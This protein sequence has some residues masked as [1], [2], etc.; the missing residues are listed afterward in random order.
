MQI[1]RYIRLLTVPLAFL[2]AIG[3]TYFINFVF[4]GN[5]IDTTLSNILLTAFVM[6]VGTVLLMWIGELITEKGISNGISL[7]I[8]AS[9]VAGIVG[10]L[11]SYIL[12]A[13]SQ[14]IPV[15]LFIIF[16]V[17]SLIILSIL[18]IKTVKEI[19]IVY[20]RHGKIEETAVLPIPLNPVGMI[21]IIFAM[22]FVS[23]PY[24]IAQ[25]VL[26]ANIESLKPIAEWISQNLNLYSQSPSPLAIFIYFVLIV[27]FTYFYTYIVFSPEKIAESIQKRGG[28]IPGIRPGEETAKYL[29]KVLAH[30]CFW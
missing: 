6:T 14:I 24:M 17:L 9:I 3:M 29:S 25:F 1:Q 28:Y 22:A 4:G 5:L 21:P 27:L 30:L 16:I 20:A 7:I 10:K 18:L 19:P 8:F 12:G 11:W 23:F 13:G 26:K 2:Q 15:L